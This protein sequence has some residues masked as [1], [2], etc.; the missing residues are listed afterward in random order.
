MNKAM[1]IINRQYSHKNVLSV[2][3]LHYGWEMVH[4]TKRRSKKYEQ[5]LH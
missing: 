2:E 1:A 5:K 3:R 4:T